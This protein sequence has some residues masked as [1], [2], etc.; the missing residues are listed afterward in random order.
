MF[1]IGTV[2]KESR[3]PKITRHPLRQVL[4]PAQCRGILA[5]E[6]TLASDEDDAGGEPSVHCNRCGHTFAF[7]G[8]VLRGAERL[9]VRCPG[10]GV[11]WLQYTIK[12][13]VAEA[14]E[15]DGIDVPPFVAAMKRN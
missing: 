4:T 6:A 10:C 1:H 12:P 11:V 15:V 5:V 7:S 14:V 13:P 2:F 9:T 3:H 8:C